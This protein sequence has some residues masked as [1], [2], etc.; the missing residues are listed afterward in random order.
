[1]KSLWSGSKRLLCPPDMK[2]IWKLCK[3]NIIITCGVSK[4][5]SWKIWKKPYPKSDTTNF[6][7]SIAD[8]TNNQWL[9]EI[10]SNVETR[11][12]PYKGQMY[13]AIPH[14]GLMLLFYNNVYTEKRGMIDTSASMLRSSIISFAMTVDCL[15]VLCAMAN[16]C[17][18]V[19]SSKY[20]N[21][22]VV[23]RGF[24]NHYCF[25]EKTPYTHPKSHPFV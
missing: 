4:A 21:I 10:E 12:F 9:K 11:L 24:T 17:N 2:I 25:E 18:K 6:P 19:K 13:K 14:G 1:M 7:V 8:I 22:R 23:S 20:I 16:S 15:F 5:S 3:N